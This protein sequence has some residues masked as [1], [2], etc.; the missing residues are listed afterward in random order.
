MSFIVLTVGEINGKIV[1][2]I[3]Q[4]ET[5]CQQECMCSKIEQLSPQLSFSNLNLISISLSHVW[6]SY[7]SYKI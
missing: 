7:K 1:R 5:E 6:Y 2:H 3:V 4:C